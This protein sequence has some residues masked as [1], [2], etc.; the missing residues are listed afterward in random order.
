[1]SLKPGHFTLACASLIELNAERAHDVTP[2]FDLVGIELG[3]FV[4]RRRARL[5]SERLDPTR[6]AGGLHDLH[7]LAAEPVEN[8]LRR[9]GCPMG[10]SCRTFLE[11]LLARYSFFLFDES[12]TAVTD[13]LSLRP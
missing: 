13:S 2:A 7:Q 8:W 10:C 4:A 3:E 5:E 12:V 1:L 6:K 9:S 11:E